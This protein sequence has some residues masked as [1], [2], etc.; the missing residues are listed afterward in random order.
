[1]TD[2][3]QVF[4][5]AIRGAGALSETIAREVPDFRRAGLAFVMRASSFIHHLSFEFRHLVS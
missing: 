2:D 4:A 3:E 1:M 5:Q